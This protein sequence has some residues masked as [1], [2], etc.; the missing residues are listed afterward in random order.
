V[1]SGRVS[2]ETAFAHCYNTDALRQYLDG[3]LR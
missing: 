1:R 3:L 2:R